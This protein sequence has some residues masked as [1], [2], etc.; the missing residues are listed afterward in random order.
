M[1]TLLNIPGGLARATSGGVLAYAELVPVSVG[2]LTDSEAEIQAGPGDQVV[3]FPS[4]PVH[5]SV[6]ASQ[7]PQ[8]R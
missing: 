7:R 3:F 2:A 8:A 6:E 5:D 1:S 4:D